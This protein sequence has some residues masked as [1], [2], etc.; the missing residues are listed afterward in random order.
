VAIGRVLQPKIEAQ[1]TLVL[2][3][4]LPSADVINATGWVLPALEIVG[5]RQ[6]A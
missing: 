1:I 3:R 6:S 2:E 5:T 4:D